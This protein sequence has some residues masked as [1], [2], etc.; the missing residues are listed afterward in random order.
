MIVFDQI[1]KACNLIVMFSFVFAQPNKVFLEV[2]YLRKQQQTQTSMNDRSKSVYTEACM[3]ESMRFSI[4]VGK[5]VQYMTMSFFHDVC[6]TGVKS[7]G[8]FH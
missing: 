5:G 2:F 7:R 1:F 6:H 4:V 8:P 3:F